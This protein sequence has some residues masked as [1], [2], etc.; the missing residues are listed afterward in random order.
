[1]CDDL[2][3]TPR[4]LIN[5]VTGRSELSPSGSDITAYGEPSDNYYGPIDP[6]DEDLTQEQEPEP[7]VDKPDSVQENLVT[8]ELGGNQETTLNT[9]PA[10]T[11]VKSTTG[12]KNNEDQDFHGAREE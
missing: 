7:Q 1:M 6:G 3:S 9:T 5:A 4:R 12:E 11:P 8:V 10:P 2:F